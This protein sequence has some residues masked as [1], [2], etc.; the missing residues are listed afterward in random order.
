M[1]IYD[2][3]DN[4]LIS[5]ALGMWGNYIETSRPDLSAERARSKTYKKKHH[6]EPNHM[7][8][9]QIYLVKRIRNLSRKFKNKAI[10]DVR[11]EDL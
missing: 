5:F 3:N 4:E 1:S 7:T 6:Y 9:N 8:D 10:T 2:A 11:L